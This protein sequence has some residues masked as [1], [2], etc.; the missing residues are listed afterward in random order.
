MTDHLIIV[1]VIVV[2]LL[3][4]GYVCWHLWRVAPVGW[5]WGVTALFILW[6]ASF[7]AAFLLNER[8]PIAVATVLYEVGNTWLIAS[9]YLLLAFLV[10]DVAT[11][12]HIIPKELVKD[13]VVGL[14][15]VAGIVSVI[16]TI[17]GIHYH[18]KYRQE[19]TI[20]T[21]KPL[22]KPLK[23]VMASDLHL[24]YH[25]GR[26]ELSRWVEMINAE[27]PDIVLFG[28]DLIDMSLRPVVE[29]Q[30]DEEL[31]RIEAPVFAVLGNH[32]FYGN[33]PQAEKF[34]AKSGITLLKDSAVHVK[35]VEVIGRMDRT[36]KSREPLARL[37]DSVPSE[38]FTILLDHQPYNLGE[39]ERENIDFQFSGHTHRG[40]VWPLSWVTD[41]MYEKSWGEYQKGNTRYYV[42]SGLGIWGAKVRIGSR[43][44]Y[45]VFRLEN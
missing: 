25:N 18:H 31:R 16:L 12:C 28:G 14:I 32:E 27:K 33:L 20:T 42:S 2:V 17:G 22:E 13:N 6:M 5:K 3:L 26:K 24:G 9:L 29:G 4:L 38:A 10:T 36:S 21:N 34:Y 19:M 45:L 7:F 43:S 8:L 41:A 35:G 1:A 11:A 39:A 37:M 40:Q 30:Y 44:E 23:I 15:G